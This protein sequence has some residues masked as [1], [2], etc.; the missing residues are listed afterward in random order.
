[1]AG[2]NEDFSLKLA[3]VCYTDKLTYTFVERLLTG[4]INKTKIL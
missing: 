1:M 4:E 3:D 2:C